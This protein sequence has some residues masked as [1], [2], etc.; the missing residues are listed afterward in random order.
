MSVTRRDGRR[1]GTGDLDGPGAKVVG[2]SLKVPRYGPIGHAVE[3]RYHEA[4]NEG[5]PL[6]V[7]CRHCATPNLLA[8]DRIEISQGRA[9]GKC[10]SCDDWYLVRW[11]DAVSL[12]IAKP[13]DAVDT[14][15]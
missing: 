14:P 2:E 13:A 9:W 8:P 3:R 11:E 5:V 1:H 10:D 4:P 7:P 12:G 6:I 15:D